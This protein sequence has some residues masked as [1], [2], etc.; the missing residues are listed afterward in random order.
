MRLILF[1]RNDEDAFRPARSS[2]CPPARLGEDA[3]GV[4]SD[5]PSQFD[6][7]ASRC[8]PPR[9]DR[10]TLG[11]R[12]FAAHRDFR[13]RARG[14]PTSPLRWTC[15][16]RARGMPGHARVIPHGP[17]WTESAGGSPSATATTARPYRSSGA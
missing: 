17:A 13:F 10:I 15:K 16:S 5:G 9:V 7:R 1:Q 6:E 12:S 4:L 3:G 8:V 14:D 11:S 2:I